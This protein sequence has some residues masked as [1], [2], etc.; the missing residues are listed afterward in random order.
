MMT[1]TLRVLVVDDHPMVLRWIRAL[2]SSVPSIQVVGTASNG[3]E[4]VALA[5]DLQADIILMDIHMRG[6]TGVD[7]TR[8]VFMVSP[9]I[10]VIVLTMLDDDDSVFA[11][12]RAG[13]R[14]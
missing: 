3:E 4:S 2:L 8:R 12:M 6:L 9:H 1:E 14:G 13:A 5:E 11:A 10:G 7:A